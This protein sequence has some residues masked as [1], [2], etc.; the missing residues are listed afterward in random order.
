[1]P[2]KPKQDDIGRKVIYTPYGAYKDKK[3]EEGVLTSFNDKYAFVRY[4]TSVRGVATDFNDLD[5]L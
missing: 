1:M 5:F 3:I 2:I 4:G